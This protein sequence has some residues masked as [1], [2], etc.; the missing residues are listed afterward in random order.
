[1]RKTFFAVLVTLGVVGPLQARDLYLLIG[2]SNMAGRG[3]VTDANRLSSERVWKFT[4]DCTWGA[5]GWGQARD[6]CSFLLVFGLLW[7][8]F[9]Q[10]AHDY[11]V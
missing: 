1:M 10:R 7:L 9:S 2:Q 5:G 8:I 4:K 3:V 11:P 6:K